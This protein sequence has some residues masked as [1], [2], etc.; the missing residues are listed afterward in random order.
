MNMEHINMAQSEIAI[1]DSNTLACIGLRMLLNNVYPKVIIRIFNDFG[2][3]VD[4]TPEMFI[5]YFVSIQTY[6]DHSAFFQSRLHQ[7]IVLSGE[8]RFIPIKDVRMLNIHQ[9]EKDLIK[10]L[11][12]LQ[13]HG[14]NMHPNDMRIPHWD[15]RM[16]DLTPREAE[17]LVLVVRGFLNKEIAETLHIG[18]STVITHRKNISEKLGTKSVSKLAIY[19]VMNGYVEADKI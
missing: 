15:K 6:M 3:F 16:H 13:Q 10:N 12:M 9:P 17:V 19:A 4:D 7:T 11:L 2:A 18:L 5:H 14:H 1:I 8:N